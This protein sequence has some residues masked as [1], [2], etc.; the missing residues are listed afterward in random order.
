MAEVEIHT[1]H[2]HGGDA[3]T[4]GVSV[5]VG[6]IG[7]V[8]AFVTIAS[9]RAHTAAVIHRTEAND[10]WSFYE[11][12]KE[13]EHLMDVG[14]GLLGVVQVAEAKKAEILGAEYVKE[15]DRYANDATKIQ[16][17]ALG[18]EAESRHEEARGLQLDLGEGLLELGLV[19]TSLYFLARKRLFPIIGVLAALAGTLVAATSYVEWFVARIAV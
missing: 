8:L 3:F 12:K 9:H 17:D 5:L 11:A 19:L 4:K 1:S 15:R 2:E 18:K 7:I 13:R 6:V 10:Q 14:A 16:Q